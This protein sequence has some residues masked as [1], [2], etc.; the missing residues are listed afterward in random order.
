MLDTQP[1]LI[2]TALLT[3]YID[4]GIHESYVHPIAIL[5]TLPSDGVG[6]ILPHPFRWNLAL[7]R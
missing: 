7:S 1:W 4:S 6:A 2:L 3:V 5:S